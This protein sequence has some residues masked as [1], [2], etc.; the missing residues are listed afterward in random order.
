[1]IMIIECSNPGLTA[2]KIRHDIIS[3]LRA[4]PSS[5]QYIKVL[6]ITHKRIMIV[7]DVGITD[8]VVDEL[9]KLISKYGVKVNVLREVNITT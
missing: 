3:Y 8:R 2:H 5:R 7:I 4:K 1:M 9:V 6:S